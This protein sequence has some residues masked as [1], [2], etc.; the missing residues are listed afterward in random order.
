MSR[1]GLLT[2]SMWWLHP[3]QKT[4]ATAQPQQGPWDSDNAF[5]IWLTKGQ[6]GSTVKS[7]GALTSQ[8]TEVLLKNLYRCTAYQTSSISLL[9]D[10]SKTLISS[11]ELKYYLSVFLSWVCL[12]LCY[13][14]RIL[15][16]SVFTGFLKQHNRL[17]TKLG[18]GKLLIACWI[19]D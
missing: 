10:C 12:T 13:C 11:S 15:N 4:F 1:H 17:H 16:D 18:F 2:T 6:L 7:A 8:F 3:D 19:K 9:N 14:C 5:F